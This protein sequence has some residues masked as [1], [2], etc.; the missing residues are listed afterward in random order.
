MQENFSI[1]ERVIYYAAISSFYFF[2]PNNLRIYR[3]DFHQICRISFYVKLEQEVIIMSVC[4]FMYFFVCV[5]GV[6][7]V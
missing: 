3:T 6:F 1:V 2:E 7:G 4:V 5:F